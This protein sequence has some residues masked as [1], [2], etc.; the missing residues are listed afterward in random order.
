MTGRLYTL[1]LF[2]LLCHC[3]AL[4]AIGAGRE[5]TAEQESMVKCLIATPDRHWRLNAERPVVSVEIELQ[6]KVNARALPSISLTAL[7][8]K[9]G[10]SVDEYWAPFSLP[11][12]KSTSEW[13]TLTNVD[14]KRSLTA[15]LSPVDLL[16]A[17]RKSSVW[18]SQAFA[19][20]VGPGEY[21]LR[22]QLDIGDDKRILSNA[23]RVSI[24]R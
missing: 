13:L 21:L 10:A 24:H 9:T 6:G 4:N 7:S 11:N 3:P 14:G 2:V 17:R 12:G 20:T 23:I 16:W 19:S 18:P 8:P 15:R 5:Y 1:I 22:L